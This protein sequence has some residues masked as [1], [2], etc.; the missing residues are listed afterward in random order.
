MDSP[1]LF[2][3]LEHLNRSPH[4][5][6]ARFIEEIK[7]NPRNVIARAKQ[8][9]L[10]ACTAV[11]DAIQNMIFPAD[12]L[13]E[14]M[15]MFTSA[16]EESCPPE[17]V[18]VIKFQLAEISFFAMSSAFV[19]VFCQEKT[20]PI[21]AVLKAWPSIL[22]WAKARFIRNIRARER[23]SSNIRED[24]VQLAM[25]LDGICQLRQCEELQ[26]VAADPRV[27]DLAMHLYLSRDDDSVHFKCI[28]MSYFFMYI[29]KSILR[30]TDGS[31]G[32]K[33]PWRRALDE[34]LAAA[35]G[36]PETILKPILDVE[37]EADKHPVLDT[38]HVCNE[39]LGRFIGIRS[40]PLA[41]CLERI[42]S[43]AVSRGLRI[44]TE[45]SLDKQKSD[46]F[47]DVFGLCVCIFAILSSPE[48]R[49]A[50]L[51]E[52]LQSRIFPTIAISC[53]Q[54]A[55]APEVRLSVMKSL[56]SQNLPAHLADPAILFVCENALSTLSVEHQ[57]QIMGS[58]FAPAWKSFVNR[59]FDL[60]VFYCYFEIAGY[61]RG[62]F[63][64]GNIASDD[65]KVTLRRCV[66][67]RNVEYCSKE[68]QMSDWKDHKRDCKS[69]KDKK[70]G[71]LPRWAIPLF[72]RRLAAF[73]VRRHLP[74]IRDRM[75]Q[76]YPCF[77]LQCALIS[78]H[79]GFFPPR[80]LVALASEMPIPDEKLMEESAN[81]LFHNLC[82]DDVRLHDGSSCVCCIVDERDP[83][84]PLHHQKFYWSPPYF[85]SNYGSICP[86]VYMRSSSVMPYAD[87]SGREMSTVWSV[88]DEIAYRGG[89]SPQMIYEGKVGE[90]RRKVLEVIVR[91]KA[92]M[93]VGP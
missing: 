31:V 86:Y 46:K 17:K 12:A 89:L 7:T 3:M 9:D 72:K 78:L 13:P 73:D 85:A 15:E 63:K 84:G 50:W 20:P 54:L 53:S 41:V 45:L 42:G 4:I 28:C 40:H 67:C 34:L 32:V 26:E 64:C 58:V 16:I 21:A 79:Y 87:E 77:P 38:L 19:L 49:K 76:K 90:I 35:G 11:R 47:G 92:R 6:Y 33:K 88:V 69:L 25:F 71:P 18:G 61:H 8:G 81:S 1:A 82:F 55:K 37:S 75:A 65:R 44:L 14:A 22:D 27:L 80:L 24:W 70:S 62:C 51:L 57:E 52:A 5:A 39:L 93:R 66:A 91:E 29:D 83:E 36:K 68:C 60:F 23:L 10:F 74:G 48:D 2:E 56:L 59:F 30:S 43:T